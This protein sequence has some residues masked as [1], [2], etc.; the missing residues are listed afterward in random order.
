[1]LE[2]TKCECKDEDSA[3]WEHTPPPS[4]LSLIWYMNT[5]ALAMNA[6]SWRNH[7]RDLFF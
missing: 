7:G 4:E 6:G 2:M 1:M 5:A 3:G